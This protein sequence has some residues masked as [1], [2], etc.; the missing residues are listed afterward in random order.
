MICFA[1]ERT[2]DKFTIIDYTKC[3]VDQLREIFILRNDPEMRKWAENPVELTWENHL[4]FVESLK[5][6]HNSIYF[7]IYMKNELIGSYNLHLV[8]DTT[9]ERGLFS[10]P[11]TQGKGLTS[12]WENQILKSLSKDRFTKIVAE[13][14][15][16]N[17]RSIRYHEKMGF[18]E[19][20]RDEEY[21]FF[22]K[23]L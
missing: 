12:E 19:T 8:Q 13:V 16:N 21:V 2:M 14:K 10:S 3:T 20:R 22:E 23:V 5:N 9:W 1:E 17:P 11:N 6:T 4:H 7:A 18:V 15:I